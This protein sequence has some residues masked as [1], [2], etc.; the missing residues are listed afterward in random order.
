[1]K[2]PQSQRGGLTGAFT[3]VEL[4]VVI[5]IIAIL[6]GILLPVLST[7]KTKAKIR[8]AQLEMSNLEAAFKTYES[9]YNRPAGYPAAEQASS[10]NPASYYPDFTYGTV[11]V[12]GYTGPAVLNNNNPSVENNNSAVMSILLARGQTAD[13]TPT[14]NAGDA[15]NTRKMVLITAKEVESVTRGG[16]GPD[17]VFRDPWGNPYIIT[18]DMNDDD[19]VTDGFYRTIGGAGFAQ[20]LNPANGMPVAPPALELAR[21]IM[22][23]SLGPDGKA[24]AGLGPKA[25]VNADNVK[26]WE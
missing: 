25:G 9:E 22:I 16:I 1:M 12:A 14:I 11:G 2:H 21:P 7:V 18:V 6:A 17:L 4:L 23:W 13:G 3:L 10:K 19:R 15:R 8:Q 5:A 20:V 24:D 26:S